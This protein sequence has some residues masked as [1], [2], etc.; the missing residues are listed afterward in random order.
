MKKIGVIPPHFIYYLE[1]EG[2]D[3]IEF[4]SSDFYSKTNYDKIIV[5]FPYCS[6]TLDIQVI[7][8]IIDRSSPPD[9]VLLNEIN[10]YMDYGEIM[11]SWNFKESNMLYLL[12]LKIK[13]M[14]SIEQEKSL[15]NIISNYK[16]NK[17]LYGN[18]DNSSNLESIEQI[19]NFIQE[20]TKN[21]KQVIKDHLYE[22]KMFFGG[23]KSKSD[24][25]S[26]ICIDQNKGE[27]CQVNITYPIDY[28]IRSRDVS[29]AP[30]LSL[31]IPATFETR[32]SIELILPHFISSELENFSKEMCDLR[33]Y[34]NCLNKME[35]K[36]INYFKNMRDRE[37]VISKII[38]S[39][40]GFPLEI[41][42]Q[43][44]MKLSL[45]CHHSKTIVNSTNDS[46]AKKNANPVVIN[47]HYL[48]YFIFFADEEKKF[49]FQIVD[50]DKLKIVSRKKLDYGIT[51]REINNLL[52]LI[53]SIISECMQ[54]KKGKI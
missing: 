11:K 49:E 47:V 44:F 3:V 12:L 31:T 30:L 25:K 53:V 6:G 27:I 19:L 35:K 33:D 50:N 43:N 14:Y 32:F 34:A 51:E 9:F 24:N 52:H 13:E 48:L 21:Y 4:K 42:T 41:Q 5:K 2:I 29:R 39:N 28:L 16:E 7:F 15:R 1:N 36:V 54:S 20:K 26:E 10:S 37:F 23:N 18:Q 45:Y 8:D 40:I 38:E 17:A 46:Q 22:I